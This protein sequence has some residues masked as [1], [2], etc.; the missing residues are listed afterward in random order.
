MEF[1][2][3]IMSDAEIPLTWLTNHQQCILN[4]IDMPGRKFNYA[5]NYFETE[6]RDKVH[7]TFV[8]FPLITNC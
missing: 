1:N 8:I 2:L 4:S 7:N 3:I 6:G 5:L